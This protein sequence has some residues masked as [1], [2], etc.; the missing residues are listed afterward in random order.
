[1]VDSKNIGLLIVGLIFGA[2]IGYLFSGDTTGGAALDLNDY[3][4]LQSQHDQLLS[5]Y[6]DVTSENTQLNSQLSTK[7]STIRGLQNTISAKESQISQLEDDIEEYLEM[8]PPPPPDE[9]EPGSSRNFPADRNVEITYEFEDWYQTYTCTVEFIELIRGEQAWTIL[10][11]TNS[12]WNEEP[13][14]G[15]EYILAKVSFKLLTIPSDEDDY[16]LSKMDFDVVSADGV[17]YDSSF[18]LIEPTPDIS[19]DLYPGA[20]HEGWAGFLVEKTDT[21]PL[22]VFRRDHGGAWFKLYD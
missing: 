4:R 18:M 7:E 8:L 3:N 16:S 9:G 22:L 19:A 6:D 17:V 10:E 13:A 1:L 12:V 15:Y 14:E 20:T 2:G 21:K 5:D 11:E